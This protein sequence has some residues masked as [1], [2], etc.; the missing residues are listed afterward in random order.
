MHRVSS[1]RCQLWN[2]ADQFDRI[3]PTAQMADD[4]VDDEVIVIQIRLHG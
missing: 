2:S 3:A 1:K 4:G